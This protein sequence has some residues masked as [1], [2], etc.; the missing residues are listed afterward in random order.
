[1]CS[2]DLAAISPGEEFVLFTPAATGTTASGAVVS[3]SLPPDPRLLLS[4]DT[5]LPRIRDAAFCRTD[6]TLWVVGGGGTAAAEG[7][8]TAKPAPEGLW[9]ID[10]ALRNGRQAANAV[11]V[12]RLEGARSVACLSE[13]AII[14]THGRE[15]HT[16]SRIDPTQPVSQP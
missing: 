9:R 5:S 6:G 10:A 16:V 8:S 1:M 12:A 3:F 13:R 14:V 2:S 7:G 15:S 4:L 11:C